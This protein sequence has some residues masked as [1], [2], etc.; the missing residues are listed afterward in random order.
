MSIENAAG[1]G[2]TVRISTDPSYY[3]DVSARRAAVIA[4]RL[5]KMVRARF[6]GADVSVVIGIIG[7]RDVFGDDDQAVDGVRSWIQE[8]WTAAL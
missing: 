1:T 6:P 5:S 7:G 3:G 2:V 8:N 4:L